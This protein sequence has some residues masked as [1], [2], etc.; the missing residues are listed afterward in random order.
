MTPAQMQAFCTHAPAYQK[1]CIPCSVRYIKMLRSPDR[2]MSR[3]LQ[4]AHLEGLPAAA[5]EQVKE[6]LRKE[7]EGQ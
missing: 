5:A 6:I 4:E 2:R 3:Q 1:G 7:R